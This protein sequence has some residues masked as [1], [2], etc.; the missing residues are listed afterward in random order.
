[1]YDFN[2]NISEIVW[3]AYSVQQLSLGDWCADAF[4]QPI[5]EVVRPGSLQKLRFELYRSWGSG[6]NST[7]P[8]LEFDGWPVSLQ[9]LFFGLDFIQP[10]AGV[11]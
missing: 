9:K 1:M 10:I 8:S 5:T 11:V 7:S 2:E 6:T 4:N 3:P